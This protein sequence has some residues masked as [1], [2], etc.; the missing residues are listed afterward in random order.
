[1]LFVIFLSLIFAG[2]EWHIEPRKLILAMQFALPTFAVVLGQTINQDDNIVAKAFLAVLI[3]VVPLQLLMGWLVGT[4]TLTHNLYFFSIYQHFQFVPLI[5]VSAY[6]YATVTLW[7]SHRTT[8]LLLF[9]VMFIY[10]LA[11]VSFLTISGFLL[12]TATFAIDRIRPLNRLGRLRYALLFLAIP[13]AITIGI[14][15]IGMYYAIAKNNTS[16]IGDHGQY[17]GKFQMLSSG[18][19]PLNLLERLEDWKRFT[20]G[21]VETPK[22]LLFGHVAPMPREIRTSAHNWY[23]DIAFTFGMLALI[24][25]LALGTYTIQRMAISWS[26]RSV[27]TKGLFFIVLYLVAIDNNFKVTLRQPYSGIFVYF[28]WGMLLARLRTDSPPNRRYWS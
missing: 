1:M 19:I 28:L 11:S 5:F 6:A 17:I 3:A 25:I 21:I 18:K 27:A 23:I 15:S 12:F 7:E 14:A 8:L 9:P 20:T 24:P 26:T 16:I 22:T 13:T 2:V 4:L 10:S